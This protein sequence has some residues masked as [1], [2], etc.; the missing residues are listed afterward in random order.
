MPKTPETVGP[1]A[2]GRV[3]VRDLDTGHERTVPAVEVGHGRYLVLNEPA[4][5][6]LTGDA[7][8]GVH[9][10]PVEPTTTSGQQAEP[11]KEIDHA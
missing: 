8:P 3:R 11:K 2:Y 1:D 7:L 10:S 9:K 5:N 4:S 6:P